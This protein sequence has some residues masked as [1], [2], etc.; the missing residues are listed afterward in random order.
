VVLVGT[1]DDVLRIRQDEF[2]VNYK[3]DGA[4]IDK[5]LGTGTLLD[6]FLKG[7]KE[8]LHSLTHSGTA[9][10]GMR[11]DGDQVGAGVSDAQ[12]TALLGAAS[13][14]AFLI[15]ILVAKHFDLRDIADAA[16]KV[17]WEYGKES[18]AAANLP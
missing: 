14:A 6:D 1:P 10:L 11:F 5:A 3:K 4:W 13:N 17:F 15:T 16:N 9:Q 12:I 2:R 7:T 8:L 18:M